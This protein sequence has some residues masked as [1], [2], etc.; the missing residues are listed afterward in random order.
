MFLGAGGIYVNAH[1][2]S[3]TS[4]AII[5]SE[6]V[7]ALIDG[8]V[9]ISG[10]TAASNGG[11]IYI[12]FFQADAPTDPPVRIAGTVHITNNS[13]PNGDGGGIFIGVYRDP[14][15]ITVRDPEL[16]RRLNVGADVVFANNSARAA[17]LLTDP[18]LI[19][20]HDATVLT[21]SFTAPFTYGYSNY[22][23]NYIEGT[24]V[25]IVTFDSQGGTPVVK[26]NPTLINNQ[27]AVP[28][29][30]SAIKPAID[31]T[32]AAE[33][34]FGGWYT[35]PACTTPYDFSMPVTTDITLYAKWSPVAVD[36]T[37]TTVAGK[38]LTVSDKAKGLLA[39]DS[40]TDLK[41]TAYTQPKDSTGAA[42]GTVTVNADGTFT[43]TPTDPHFS[44]KVTFFYTITN[45]QSFTSTA[46]VTI[47][48]LPPLDLPEGNVVPKKDIPMTGDSSQV[49]LYAGIALAAA[50]LAAGAILLSGRRRSIIRSH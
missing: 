21:H 43:Y 49:G 8:N 22:D 41:V 38:T 31:P 5:S 12:D 18:V 19:A 36:D 40:G 29:S 39:N 14:S 35:D 50:L 4:G 23:I 42:Q 48:V 27:E 10:N 6:S 26:S 3:T 46:T 24:L 15:N 20:I 25:Y 32:R 1:T 11:G 33:D 45:D 30:T 2:I 28:A 16:Y 34:V 13:A 44:G 47:T 37:A 17:Y 7:D 9:V